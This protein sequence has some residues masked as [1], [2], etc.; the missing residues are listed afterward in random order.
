VK[1]SQQIGCEK[2]SEDNNTQQ[3][4][5]GCGRI[6]QDVVSIVETG[7]RK[8][9]YLK[10]PMQFPL[11]LSLKDAESKVEQVNKAK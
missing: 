2:Y 10:V 1:V 8:C 7:D 11:V 3:N 4:K 6:V 5:K 9:N